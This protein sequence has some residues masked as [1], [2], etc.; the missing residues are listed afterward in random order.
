MV[1]VLLVQL[2]FY[3]IMENVIQIVQIIQD[4]I[5]ISVSHVYNLLVKLVLLIMLLVLLASV[6]IY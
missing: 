2:H 5:I 1:D 3:N 4:Q 6:G